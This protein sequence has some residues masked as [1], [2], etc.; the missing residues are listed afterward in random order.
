[1][2]RSP[3]MRRACPCEP[4]T[5]LIPCAPGTCR[6]AL[7]MALALGLSLPTTARCQT[8]FD[9]A[10]LKRAL[11]DLNAQLRRDPL[12]ANAYQA[13]G[14]VNFKLGKFNDAIRDYDKY[15]ELRPEQRAGHWQRGI[16]YYYADKYDAGRR[17]FEDCQ[18]TDG[19]DVENAVWHFM[20]VAKKDGLAKARQTM[21]KVGVDR[22]VP[23]RE[24]YALFSGKL[25]PA[26][27]LAAAKAGSPSRE[28]LAQRLFYAHLY[29]GIYDDLT[30]NATEASRNVNEAVEKHHIDHYMWDVARI[31]RDVLKAHIAGAKK[32]QSTPK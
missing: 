18:K 22:R 1:M 23:M 8:P 30:G 13:R 26:D 14:S 2:N 28:A 12:L 5:T 21:L 6:A 32:G 10:P 27:V 29:V 20:C 31:Q 11:D 19:N 15:L 16:A 3:N 25:K 24:V 9:P 4:A 7:F 17:Q